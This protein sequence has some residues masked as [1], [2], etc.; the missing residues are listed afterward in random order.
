VERGPDD[1]LAQQVAGRGWGRREELSPPHLGLNRLT[2]KVGDDLWLTGID[3]DRA[4]LLERENRLLHEVRSACAAST[5]QFDVPQVVPT[6]DGDDVIRH[7]GRA[8]RATAN[9]PGVRPDANRAETYR[10]STLALRHVH[11]LLREIPPELGVLPPALIEVGELLNHCL[12]D[13][14]APV[15]TDPSEPALVGAVAEYLAPRLARLEDAPQQLIHGDWSTPNLLVDSTNTGHV[16]AVLDWQLCSVGPVIADI[17]QAASGALMFADVA[18]EPIVDSIFATYG[19]GAD[20][21]LLG[22][23]M[24]AYWFR[25]YWWSREEARRDERLRVGLDRQPGRLRSVLQYAE[26]LG[27]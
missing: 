25:N 3:E 26:S 6:V 24:A 7:G 5:V 23:A 13:D 12:T 27:D 17:A 19:A 2:W 16:V 1:L 21:R 14:W 4:D 20:R 9:I 22:P 11:T 15:T 8:Y 10:G 18:V